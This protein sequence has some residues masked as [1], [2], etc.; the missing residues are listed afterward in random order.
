MS[1]VSIWAR[2][3]KNLM[4]CSYWLSKP[5]VQS[6]IWSFTN[7]TLFL[8]NESYVIAYS[9]SDIVKINKIISPE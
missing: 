4:E 1:K 8:S 3:W 5:V 2:C 7:V 9:H 6:S